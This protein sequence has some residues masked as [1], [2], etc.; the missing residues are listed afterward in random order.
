M[1]GKSDRDKNYRH[2]TD[3]DIHDGLLGHA[4]PYPGLEPVARMF[5]RGNLNGALRRLGYE[6]RKNPDAPFLYANKVAI[7][8]KLSRFKE[9]LDCCRKMLA[10]DKDAVYVH[11][12][13]G[14]VL[15]LSGE[16]ANAIPYHDTAIRLCKRMGA[17]NND[18]ARM[19]NNKAATLMDMDKMD[20]ALD[21]LD[22]SIKAEPGNITSYSNKVVLLY[23]M[24][25]IDEAAKCFVI[26]KRLDP[27]FVIPI[28][29]D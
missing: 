21:C 18:I 1:Q 17:D 28:E 16:S 25:R 4:K 11:E 10:L 7:L 27:N 26:A 2:L 29:L 20:E 23:D 13:M 5:R 14:Q 6:I 12:K 8:I 22:L 3:G 24:G 15:Q 9:A 19:Y